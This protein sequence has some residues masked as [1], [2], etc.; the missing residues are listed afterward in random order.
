[1]RH[2]GCKVSWESGFRAKMLFFSPVGCRSLCP[3]KK[4][5]KE[6]GGHISLRRG[7]WAR[8][9]CRG[10]TETTCL[11]PSGHRCRT[12]PG[13]ADNR[14]Q[15]KKYVDQGSA[16]KKR[17]GSRRLPATGWAS[18]GLYATRCLTILQ[19]RKGSYGRQSGKEYSNK[20]RALLVG[21]N[22]CSSGS[23]TTPHCQKKRGSL[24]SKSLRRMGGKLR[25]RSR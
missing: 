15:K 12:K 1:M 23:R 7:Y 19:Q 9:T 21:G 6:S 24:C 17:E 13:C 2:L 16:Y 20:R 18:R 8:E 14:F 25:Y 22:A 3:T 4:T 5:G 10:P 11:D